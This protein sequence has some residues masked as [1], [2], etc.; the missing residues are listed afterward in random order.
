MPS[1]TTALRDEIRRLARKEINSQTAVLKKQSAQYRRDIADLKRQVAD[2]QRRISFVE[3]QEKRRIEKAPSVDLADTARFSP[4]WLAS[5]REKLGLSA[6]D[7]GTLVG[8]S[9]LTIYNWEQGK[10]KPQKAQIA[11]WAAIRG[12]GKREAAKRLE[13]IG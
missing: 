2:F 9:Q 4:K 7:Y 11:K 8:V 12:L 5:H 13:L 6:A 1:L 10:S 3:K